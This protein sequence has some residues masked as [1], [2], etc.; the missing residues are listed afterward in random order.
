VFIMNAEATRHRQLRPQNRAAASTDEFTERGRAD[1]HQAQPQS[2]GE[3]KPCTLVRNPV[4]VK[5]IGRK[6]TVTK[7]ETVFSKPP[8]TRMI[9]KHH[10][11]DESA[12]DGEHAE[13]VGNQPEMK[14]TVRMIA[15][16]SWGRW[17]LVST[18][19]CTPRLEPRV[20]LNSTK[21]DAVTG[22][23]QINSLL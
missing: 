1:D 5:K 9:V 13:F 6:N 23:M 17:S 15:S 20:A 4:N 18:S 22:R 7:C 2:R 21:C 16:R 8:Q 19:R 3:F 11:R 12:E 14:T 10:A